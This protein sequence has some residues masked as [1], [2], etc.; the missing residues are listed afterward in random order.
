MYFF[1]LIRLA[2]IG[3]ARGIARDELRGGLAG[4]LEQRG[5]ER[6]SHTSARRAAG[7]IGQT[8][9]AAAASGVDEPRT[10]TAAYP[11]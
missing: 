8:A 5:T 6:I 7:R 9:G 1:H 11:W 4:L 3:A 10:K 2:S